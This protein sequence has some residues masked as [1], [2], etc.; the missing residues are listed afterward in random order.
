MVLLV[1]VGTALAGG[2]Q[3]THLAVGHGLFA[4]AEVE[5]LSAGCSHGCCAARPSAARN[6]GERPGEPLQREDSRDHSRCSLCDLIAT[7]LAPDSAEREHTTR[8]T[9]S[10]AIIAPVESRVLPAMSDR[11]V[12]P[13]PPPTGSAAVLGSR[14]AQA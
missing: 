3:L 11:P 2:A 4:S 14:R 6:S 5:G 10:P 1:L 13:R 9:G 7:L 8:E 12:A